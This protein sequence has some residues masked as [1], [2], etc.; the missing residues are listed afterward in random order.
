MIIIGPTRVWIIKLDLMPC[1]RLDREVLLI[2]LFA[3]GIISL[4]SHLHLFSKYGSSGIRRCLRLCHLLRG[5]GRLCRI[6]PWFWGLTF[7]CFDPL[8]CKLDQA[9]SFFIDP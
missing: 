4:F 5:R 7:S 1:I 9:Y 3:R 8:L 6:L 2:Y